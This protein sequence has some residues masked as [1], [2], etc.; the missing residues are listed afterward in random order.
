M[1]LCL[2]D[3]MKSILLTVNRDADE[4][5]N[6]LDLAAGNTHWAQIPENEVVI[7]AIGLELVAFRDELFRQGLSV[8]NHLGGVCFPCW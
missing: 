1:C 5:A 4:I 8:L 6:L 2:H 3:A 7:R